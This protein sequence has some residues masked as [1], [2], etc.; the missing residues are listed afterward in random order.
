MYVMN[1]NTL[2]NQEYFGT[3]LGYSPTIPTSPHCGTFQL[4][5]LSFQDFQDSPPHHLLWNQ[6]CLAQLLLRNS[7]VSYQKL[8]EL[9]MH[10]VC[11]FEIHCQVQD[12]LINF[13]FTE[14]LQPTHQL[15]Y[16]QYQGT[17]QTYN[18]GYQNLSKDNTLPL[19]KEN[20]FIDYSPLPNSI[21]L[22]EPPYLGFDQPK[23]SPSTRFVAQKKAPSSFHQLQSQ[24]PLQD[25]KQTWP[26][27]Q[28]TPSLWPSSPS[29]RG[30]LLPCRMQPQLQLQPHWRALLQWSLQTHPRCWVP[31]T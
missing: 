5:P 23:T 11:L 22:I 3:Y 27:L 1:G 7:I 25:A 8:Q 6:Y 19:R 12:N 4:I 28:P 15:N 21:K 13:Y 31:M 14:S 26:P 2:G 29:F 9:V 18:T 30:K 17:H 10:V 24:L 16:L 20:Y